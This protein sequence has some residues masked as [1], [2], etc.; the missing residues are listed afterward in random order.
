MK[1][2]PKP[3]CDRVR[4]GEN[5]NAASRHRRWLDST[6]AVRH[7]SA[8]GRGAETPSCDWSAPAGRCRPGTGPRH[9]RLRRRSTGSASE[10]H[11]SPREWVV[12]SIGAST[13]AWQGE[14]SLVYTQAIRLDPTQQ[15]RSPIHGGAPCLCLHP[16]QGVATAASRLKVRGPR[17]RVRRAA[18]ER[19]SARPCLL[20]S[21]N[22][23]PSGGS[24]TWRRRRGAG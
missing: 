4:G 12:I 22:G 17:S 10:C 15:P 23:K 5:Q 7:R 8:R 6:D 19:N 3:N 1:I 9:V 20:A 11:P 24:A 21:P 2:G 16:E 13:A 14:A 18:G